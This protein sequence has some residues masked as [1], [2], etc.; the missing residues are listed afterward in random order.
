M[1]RN[2]AC[3]ISGLISFTIPKQIMPF[4]VKHVQHSRLES[5]DFNNLPF[6]RVFSDHMF[7]AD[8]DGRQW[9][10]MGINPYAPLS[11]DPSTAVIHYGQSIFEGLKAYRSVTD[12]ILLFRHAENY[13]RMCNSA[14]RMS[15]PEIPRDIFIDGMEQLI[16]LDSAWVPKGDGNSLYIRPVYFATDPV[17]GVHPSEQYKF[18]ILT[19]PSGPYYSHDLKVRIEKTYSRASRSGT[20]YAKAAGNYAG[21]L[22]PT[23]L[24]KAAGYDQV[25]WTDAATNT[26]VEE[27]GTMNLMFVIEGVLVTPSLS[28]SK[29]AGVTRDSVI[30]IARYWGMPVE[31]RDV[32]VAEVVD[33]LR[34]GKLTEA[35]GTGTAANIATISVIAEEGVDY[36]VPPVD[37]SS[38]STRASR[39][40]SKLKSGHEHDPFGWITEL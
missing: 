38:F 7:V 16:R 26:K 40:L 31:E 1:H 35:F 3:F 5:V 4:P 36:T 23:Q 37:A 28:A 24:A 32:Y 9:T 15:M 21:A 39:F 6:G 14:I 29:L 13:R 33:A 12:S 18:I 27:S 10:N 34:N 19:C 2:A 20:G 25:I 22:Y 17:I 8:F 30:E 11:L